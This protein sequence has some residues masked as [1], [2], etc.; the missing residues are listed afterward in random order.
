MCEDKEGEWAGW[1]HSL[2][3][4]Y[5]PILLLILDKSHKPNWIYTHA[6]CIS[7]NRCFNSQNLILL[8]PLHS[9]RFYGVLIVVIRI[10][11]RVFIVGLLNNIRQSFSLLICFVWLENFSQR[12]LFFNAKRE[13]RFYFT[14]MTSTHQ[15]SD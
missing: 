4:Y 1:F 8:I 10:M 12:N 9:I 3:L 7:R 11:H 2:L 15:R 5:L 14:L 13:F 6:L